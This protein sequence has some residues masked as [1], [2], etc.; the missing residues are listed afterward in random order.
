MSTPATSQVGHAN[1]KENYKRN[2]QQIE[3]VNN[4]R[5]ELVSRGSTSCVERSMR[6]AAEARGFDGYANVSRKTWLTGH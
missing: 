3:R 5:V 6:V 4:A 1:D 2:Y